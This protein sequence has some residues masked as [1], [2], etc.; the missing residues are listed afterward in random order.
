MIE[1][2]IEQAF[3][4][5]IQQKIDDRKNAIKIL[6]K[7]F[8]KSLRIDEGLYKSGELYCEHEIKYAYD[9]YIET[10]KYFKREIDV[11]NLDKAYQYVRDEI[12]K[13]R[14]FCLN[15]PQA[16]K[17]FYAYVGILEELARYEF[18]AD[19]DNTYGDNQNKTNRNILLYFTLFEDKIMQ[20]I[21]I[22]DENVTNNEE[23][24][25]KLNRGAEL[26]EYEQRHLS[27]ARKSYHNSW[28]CNNNWRRA[29]ERGV[30]D[31]DRTVADLSHDKKYWRV[32]RNSSCNALL[33]FI[34]NI[35]EMA[36]EC[37][38]N[39]K[40]NFKDYI[41]YLR[42]QPY[43]FCFIDDQQKKQLEEAK[44]LRKEQSRQV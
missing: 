9:S 26:L 37:D 2:K 35:E 38:H 4:R 8:E 5:T 29:Y 21:K 12:N 7:L 23:I 25:Y 3:Q 31:K 42:N 34:K 44:R 39:F 22:L 43:Y 30:Y 41:K 24:E 32:R 13:Y 11:E 27:G 19:D 15:T 40:S 14:G 28:D 18:V 1:N 10:Q 33:K 6:G 16:K 36:R 17:G 20:A